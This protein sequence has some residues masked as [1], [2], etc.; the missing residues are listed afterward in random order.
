MSDITVEQKLQLVHQ[1]R[2]EHNRNQNAIKNREQI[3]YGRTGSSSYQSN[4]EEATP[5]PTSFKARILIAISV[6]VIIIILDIRQESMLGITTSTI[7]TEIAKDM[8]ID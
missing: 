5:R 7:F 8:E 4:Y 1:I 3:L 6:L 2:S